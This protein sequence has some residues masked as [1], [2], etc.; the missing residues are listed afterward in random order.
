[1]AETPGAV[2]SP[3]PFSLPEPLKGVRW[4]NPGR[5][6][7]SQTLPKP[8]GCR[9]PPSLPKGEGTATA[10]PSHI[11]THDHPHADP[12]WETGPGPQRGL[13]PAWIPALD[14]G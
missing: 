14:R 2:H 8:R 13:E 5:H 12:L 10:A 1:M 6:P 7:P 9:S 3:W 11:L 4:K